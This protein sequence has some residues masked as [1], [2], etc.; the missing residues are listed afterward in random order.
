MDS[1]QRGPFSGISRTGS[2]FPDPTSFRKSFNR[3]SLTLVHQLLSATEFRST[4]I[5]TVRGSSSCTDNCVGSVR[6]DICKLASLFLFDGENI[7]ISCG[8]S[9]NSTALDG[10][11]WI[12]DSEPEPSLSLQINSKHSYSR[13]TNQ[14]ASLDSVPYKAAR[15]SHQE[16]SYVFSVEPGQKFIRLHFSQDSY[17]GFK[18]SKSLF[19]VKAG[20]Y[21]LLTNFSPALTSDALGVKQLIKE[22]C[23]N[24]DQN[25]ALTLTF[26][27]AQKKRKSHKFYAF[28][29]G[30]EVVSMPTGLYYTPEGDLGALVVGKK[31]RF[32]IDNNTALELVQ[33]LNVGGNAVS[34]SQDSSLFRTWDDDSNYLSETG[35][36][37]VNS[38]ITVK[39]IDT[40]TYTAP[41]KVYQ[42][43]RKMHD[44]SKMSGNNNITWKIPV[45]LGFRY[46][47]RLHFS[48]FQPSRAESC[49]TDFPVVINNQIAEDN[50]N[51]IQP[52]GKTGVVVH[53]DYI[54]MMEGDKMAGKRYLSITF[55][56]KPD[57]R[58]IQFNGTLNGLEVFKL[59]NP[60][61]NL[62]G[63]GPV[64]EPKSSKPKPRQKK[65]HSIYST[66][67]NA[68]VLTVILALINIAVYNLRRVSG[69]N[70]ST[71]KIRP[72]SVEHPCRQFSIDEI[73]SSTND[74][75]PQF[76]I[77]SGGYGKVYKGSIDGGSTIVAI[78]RSRLSSESRQGDTQFWTEIKML[79][80]IR[81]EH[82]VSLIG[83]CN[84]G[85]ERALVYQYMTRGTIADHLYK[86]N[87]SR[88]KSNPPLNWELRLKISIEAARGLYYLHSRHR[89]IHRDVKSSNILLDKD[90]V[91]KISDFGLSKMGPA[92][93][94]FT[95]ISTNVKGTFGYLDPEYFLTRKLTRKSDVYAFGVVL[96][97]VLSGRPAVDIRLE[98]EQHS[99]AGWA[100]YCIREG[101]VDRLI[102]Q[103][104]IGQI[105]PACLKVFVG[106]SG[107]CLHTQPQGR[108][109][110]AD[111]VMGLELALVLQQTTDTMDQVE[112]EENA[113]KIYSDQSDGV[114]SMDDISLT[115]PKG[116]SDRMT[117]DDH[118]PRSSSTRNKGRDH[119]NTKTNSN[120]T[121][122]W[123]WDP[124]GILP[125]TPSK[126]KSLPFL[127]QAVIHQFSLQE[128]HKATN[129]F[130][131]SL[132]IGYGGS[133]N[134]YK[135][136]I[137]NGQKAVAIR[138]SKS[139]ESR[140]YMAHELQS[141]KEIQMKPSPSQDNVAC[142][143]GYCE[144]ESDMILVYEHMAN[145]TLYDHLH[146]PSKDP[147]PWKRRLQIGRGAARG[148]IYIRS[149]VKRTMLHRDLKSTN[150][151]LDENWVPKV[152]E[153]GLFRNKG[154]NRVP[155]IV[156]GNWGH[157]DS[158]YIRG[159]HLT[160]KSYVFSFGLILFE[161]VFV[162]KESG[163]WFD[164]EQVS[165]AQWIKSSM[166]NNLSGCIDP[167][168]VGRASPDSLKI[169]IETAGR[170]LLDHGNDRPS[171]ADIV[172]RLEAAI[173]QQEATEGNN[174]NASRT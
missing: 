146:E 86:I 157:L 35:A 40:P 138:W 10:R 143:I 170:C 167:F 107:R 98:E 132:I 120:S 76:H 126:S 91:A 93:D 26:T 125:R 94:S 74:F 5:K 106:I 23:I 82:L 49:Q 174:G 21:T 60:D 124:F 105:S 56:P 81:H 169:F 52:G 41:I 70:P 92:N 18:T 137:D 46:L 4:S 96:F 54:V 102:D 129:N 59:S 62:A 17:K 90:W 22:Y 25:R 140:L 72:S 150:I 28:V 57:E 55:K 85:H 134:V 113:V 36:V 30:I 148:L 9:G 61:N 111:V 67:F 15:L 153:W 142:L 24:I 116:E 89:V 39:Y 121:S 51:F 66:N 38:L 139:I 173:K 58:D 117:S 48:E 47:I 152:S 99:L 68:T 32:Y 165:L 162:D 114:I 133:D 78:K 127:S 3:S 97:E 163:R 16:F 42:T 159:E 119:K 136:Y 71:K 1:S 6:H 84:D 104:L 33:R 123:W 12:G 135:G 65:Q 151:W 145:G 44:N 160:E 115:P 80:K 31:Y 168:L 103:E 14:L 20:P 128:I 45:D 13:A 95:H 131:N 69:S 73:R 172:T 149:I 154:N 166:R 164:E 37:S 147:L 79:S 43:A 19:T 34:A 63:V 29:N 87:R 75:D 141:K 100:R 2:V 77:G 158:D 50:I 112:E 83:Y 108:P 11:V 144:T 130:H 88:L 171:M 53:K 156:R 8:S 7:A 109:A 122:R 118:P 161:L 64:P 155:T 101:K 110:M 27:P